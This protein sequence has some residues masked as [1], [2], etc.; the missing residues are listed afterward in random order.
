MDWRSW[1]GKSSKPES[2]DKDIADFNQSMEKIQF[3]GPKD[4]ALF[5]M[6]E[7]E[8]VSKR[9]FYTLFRTTLNEKSEE[10]T[11]YLAT[12]ANIDA[13]LR[14][15]MY[16]EQIAQLAEYPSDVGH[17]VYDVI[18]EN[19]RLQVFEAGFVIE[20][21]PKWMLGHG[22]RVKYPLNFRDDVTT[23]RKRQLWANVMD[24]LV[25]EYVGDSHERRRL[26][27][28]RPDPYCQMLMVFRS[29]KENGFRDVDH[30]LPQ[31]ENIVNALRHKGLL[32]HDSPP[33]LSFA[34]EWKQD[35]NAHAPVID[36]FA[37]TSEEA[38]HPWQMMAMERRKYEL[39]IK[40]YIRENVRLKKQIETVSSNQKASHHVD[41][42]G[43]KIEK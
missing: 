7:Y 31:F 4:V 26:V 11:R 32:F 37:F 3:R 6:Y 17:E 28:K 43:E 35:S 40:S 42:Q 21:I 24:K 2:L 9:F 30:Y 13:K 34:F 20:S 39:M 5:C 8:K 38:L 1:I 12:V 29:E 22:G 19:M 27:Q 41:A 36:L 33:Y 15:W 10:V 14:H 23:I 18:P 16:D 25:E